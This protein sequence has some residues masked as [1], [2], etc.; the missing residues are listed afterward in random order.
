VAITKSS[1]G[2][3]ERFKVCRAAPNTKDAIRPKEGSEQR[4]SQRFGL[5]HPGDRPP[6][7]RGQP[8]GKKYGI[9]PREVVGDEDGT[10]RR[11]DVLQ[12][13]DE[14]FTRKASK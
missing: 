5:P 11:R 3:A 10:T 14:S 7:C 1:F 8:T 2:K 13:L 9:D 4:P 6:C 12:T